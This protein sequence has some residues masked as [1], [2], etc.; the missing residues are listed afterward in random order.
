MLNSSFRPFALLSLAAIAAPAAAL[1]AQPAKQAVAST[2]ATVDG[3]LEVRIED[4]RDG[5]SRERHFVKTPKGRYELRFDKRPT[6]L[7]SG[8]KVRVH[9]R[10][11]AGVMALDGAQVQQVSAALSYAMGEQSVAVI[12]VNFS[13][14]ASQPI[15]Q[16]AANTLVFDSLDGFYQENS[17]GQT[18][19]NGQVF[20]YY[21]IAQS[22]TVCDPDTLAAQAN[23]AAAAAGVD[24]S[25]FKRKVYLHPLVGAC[26][27]SGLGH[28]GGATTNAWA[29]GTFDK[30][31]I[32]HELGHNLGLK[33]AHAKNC[34]VAPLGNTCTNLDYG[35]AA[36]LMGNIRPA[37]FN[38]FQ[39]ERLGWLN[40]G[41]SP[42]MH[43]VTASG[44]FTIQPYSS[45]SVGPKA[46]K[47]PKGLDQFGWPSY[48]YVEYRQRVGADSV[49]DMGNMAQGVVVRMATPQDSNSSFQLDMTPASSTNT[50][51]EL[52]D[53][54]LAVGRTYTDA[55]NGVSITLVS[56][57]ANGAIV[58]VTV[59]TQTTPPPTPPPSGTLTET[60]GLDKASYLRGE[61]VS[62]SALVKQD[63]VALKGASVTF[64]VTLPNA[65][66]TTMAAT[67]GTDGFARAAYKTAKGKGAVGGYGVRADATNSG[68]TATANTTFSVK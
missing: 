46:I 23:A 14:D 51:I 50:N 42:P 44:R 61:T 12:L 15:T 53:G 20:G 13:D 28:V 54:A 32:G 56:A 49:L 3:E 25:R 58:D 35:D 68:A 16:N 40:D 59:G 37:H 43:N 48:Y 10:K 55:A 57:D 34:D 52:A 7:P 39:K 36:D 41:V 6:D 2:T 22:R 63:G 65:A 9:G 64:T 18:W 62:M 67:T 4:Y 33:H 38:A 26:Q 27:W 30:L 60:I 47:I 31:V 19:L 29:N 11:A 5:R 21:T 66:K 17:F 45:T 1:A 8:T 24:L